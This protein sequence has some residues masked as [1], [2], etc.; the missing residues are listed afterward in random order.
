MS[1]TMPQKRV[2]LI[3]YWLK[4]TML[5]NQLPLTTLLSLSKLKEV[6]SDEDLVL[7]LLLNE[8]SSAAVYG[9]PRNTG[10]LHAL[11]TT[12][13]GDLARYIKLQ[14][15]APVHAQGLQ[16][17]L[18]NEQTLDAQYPE[19][20]TVQDLSQDT[21]LVV[22]YPGFFGGPQGPEHCN[23]LVTTLLKLSYGYSNYEVMAR[24]PLFQ[25]YLSR[26]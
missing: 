17:R 10:D 8:A 7:T 19:P 4:N 6:T 1:I 21:F 9:A 5:R 13:D 15:L 2:F 16:D 3:P 23:E 12:T 18:F 24:D 26:L 11:W 22:I 14:D 20:F 25:Q